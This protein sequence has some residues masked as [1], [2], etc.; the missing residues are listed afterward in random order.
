MIDFRES[1]FLEF[2]SYYIKKEKKV[3]DINTNQASLNKNQNLRYQQ[4]L[5]TTLENIDICILYITE[6][7]IKWKFER[8]G[9]VEKICLILGV[10]ELIMGLT[11]KDIVVSEWVKLT[12]KHSSSEGAKFVNGL[13]ENI[14]KEFNNE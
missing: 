12:D 13:L 9:S 1:L 4:L 2:F 3:E 7:S 8:I 6:K 5:S 11:K 10:S 14:Y